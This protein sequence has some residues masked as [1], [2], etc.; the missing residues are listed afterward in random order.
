MIYDISYKHS[1]RKEEI[2]NCHIY[3]LMHT[4]CSFLDPETAGMVDADDAWFC[5][6]ELKPELRPRQT[7]TPFRRTQ[8][9]SKST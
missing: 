9:E 2:L 4:L 3:S 8:S 7:S 6:K 1:S 5:L